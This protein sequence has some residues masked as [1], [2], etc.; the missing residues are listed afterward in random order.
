MQ[1]PRLERDM[2]KIFSAISVLFQPVRLDI[3]SITLLD[4]ILC[5]FKLTN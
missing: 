4:A 1:L 2:P 3:L 5:I